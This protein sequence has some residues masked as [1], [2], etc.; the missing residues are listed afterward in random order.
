MAKNERV[1]PIDEAKHLESRFRKWT[2]NPEKILRNYIEEGMIILDIGC[3]TGFFTI[4]MAE[5]VGESGKVIAV[6]IQQGMLEKVRMKIKGKDIENRIIFH[7]NEQDKIGVTEKVDFILAFYV[8]HEV[9]DENQF[10]EEIFSILKPNGRFY[11]V[12]PKLFH[13]SRKDFK[14]TEEK[15]VSIG[16]LSIDRPRIFLSRAIL[17]SRQS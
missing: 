11:L 16:F 8:L 12:E 15:A 2:Q 6:D 4:P 9:P 17:F 10:L 14:K 13:V 3:G 7:K 1:F 5:I